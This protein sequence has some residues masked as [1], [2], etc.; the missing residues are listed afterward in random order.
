MTCQIKRSPNLLIVYGIVET[1]VASE[2]ETHPVIAKRPFRASP[3]R[4]IN[5][6]GSDLRDRARGH[7]QSSETTS[8]YTAGVDPIEHTL[9]NERNA[10]IELYCL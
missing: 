1:H 9:P 6:S 3:S 10:L 4:G 7:S 2:G 5:L 8:I